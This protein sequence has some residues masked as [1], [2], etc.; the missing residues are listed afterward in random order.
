ML[1]RILLLAALLAL[2]GAPLAVAPPT[3]TESWEKTT[4][5]WFETLEPGGT[6]RVINAFG[7]IYA[8]FG[9][10]EGRLEILATRQRIDRDLPELEIRRRHTGGGFELTVGPAGEAPAAAPERKRRD[11]VD[12]VLFVPKGFVLDARTEG[13]GI[14][15]KGLRSDLVARSSTGDIRVRSVQGHVR[16]ES[17]GG[18]VSATLETGATGEAQ[19]I[20][21]ETGEIEVHLWEDADFQVEIATSGEISTDFSLHIEHLRFKEPGKHATATIGRGGPAL[22]LLSKRGPVRLLRLQKDFKR[23]D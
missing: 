1:G 4:S 11:R 3:E 19:E 8:R 16:L 17:A 18:Q 21:T 20:R 12:L 15:A 2:P 22:T 5:Q 10:Y 6:V 9:G 23:Q 14:E 13:G 7:S